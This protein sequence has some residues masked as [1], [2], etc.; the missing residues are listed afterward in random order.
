MIARIR[1]RLL[2]M[3]S[4]VEF[5]ASLE[6]KMRLLLGYL[7][8][9]GLPKIGSSG[10]PQPIRLRIL[11]SV[12]TLHLGKFSDFCVFEE[13]FMKEEYARA[14]DPRGLPIIDVGGNIGLTAVYFALKFPSSHIYALE[15]DPSTFAQLL[16][17]TASFS[18]IT[19]INTGLGDLDGAHTFY[20][21]PKS[22]LSSSFIQ[23][24]PDSR[25]ISVPMARFSSWLS[26]QQIKEVGLVKFDIEGYEDKFFSGIADTSVA[27]QYIGELHFDLMSKDAA[28]FTSALSGH[29]VDI[30]PINSRRSILYASL[31]A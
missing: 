9:W 5:G 21:H 3:R 6:D 11:G 25:P 8:A 10:T 16:K 17:N 26:A 15:P 14:Q 27:H 13:V 28:W 2:Y 22:S 19:C 23:R 7:V 30:T 29:S 20:V 1:Q 24:T 4:L 31:K 18:N 12:V